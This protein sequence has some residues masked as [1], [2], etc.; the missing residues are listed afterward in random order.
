MPPLPNPPVARVVVVQSSWAQTGGRVP[1]LVAA[2]L[3]AVATPGAAVV[4][5]SQPPLPPGPPSPPPAPAAES[6]DARK[7]RVVESVAAMR[8]VGDGAGA[9]THPS[10]PDVAA[11]VET[12]Q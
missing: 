5:R 8:E 9:H 4:R 3:G 1:L 11:A 10:G 7:A 2:T 6:A 12:P